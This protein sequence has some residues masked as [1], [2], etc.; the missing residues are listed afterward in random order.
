M[1]ASSLSLALSPPL[2][3]S[4][5][6]PLPPLPP[7]PSPYSAP[8]PSPSLSGLRSLQL[9]AL[10]LSL[11]LALPY[12][13]GLDKPWFPIGIAARLTKPS[14]L[15]GSSSS[16][17]M[18]APRWLDTFP[19]VLDTLS[20]CRTPERVSSLRSYVFSPEAYLTYS[21]ECR[22]QLVPETLCLP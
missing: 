22:Q 2:S 4:P 16:A 3:P 14:I 13:S 1:E 17:F 15:L 10:A 8:S 18:Q 21:E 19:P 11:S 12:T 6:S 5:L 7:S 20:A 9:S